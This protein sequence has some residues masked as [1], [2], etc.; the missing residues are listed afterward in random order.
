MS[1]QD[2]I[3]KIHQGGRRQGS[4]YE[5]PKKNAG[6]GSNEIRKI[7]GFDSKSSNDLKKKIG[8]KTEFVSARIEKLAD[9]LALFVRKLSE[10]AVETMENKVK[11][12]R[13][14]RPATKPDPLENRIRIQELETGKQNALL[15]IAQSIPS[16]R[17]EISKLPDYQRATFNGLLDKLQ[18][19][20]NVG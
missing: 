17:I 12:V 5:L 7:V 14:G 8:P 11:I 19:L 1:A 13:H 2:E 4:P 9:D 10:E 3:K 18:N 15:E 16:L 20:V 6:E